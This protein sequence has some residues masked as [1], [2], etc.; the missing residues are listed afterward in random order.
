MSHAVA[1]GGY[2]DAGEECLEVQA[3]CD[4][5]GLET[6]FLIPRHDWSVWTKGELIQRAMPYLGAEDRELLISGTCGRCFAQ[7]FETGGAA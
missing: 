4:T 6:H 7:L 5:C 1:Q 3:S 2:N